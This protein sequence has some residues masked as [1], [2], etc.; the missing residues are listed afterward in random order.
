MME[1]QTLFTTEEKIEEMSWTSIWK[2]HIYKALKHSL[3][4]DKIRLEHMKKD[5]LVFE[6]THLTS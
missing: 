4:K 3:K 1:K 6:Q 5:T 2:I